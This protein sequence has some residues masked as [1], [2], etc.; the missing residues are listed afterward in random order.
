M[1]EHTLYMHPISQVMQ[2][3]APCRSE[4]LLMSEEDLADEAACRMKQF[5]H[6]EDAVCLDE[7]HASDL[8]RYPPW[9]QYC[10]P[11]WNNR[12][13]MFSNHQLSVAIFSW[14]F[15]SV[16]LSQ[17]SV[18]VTKKTS[19]RRSLGRRQSQSLLDDES[20]HAAMAFGGSMDG[21]N[22]KIVKWNNYE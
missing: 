10:L 16:S 6:T 15:L 21:L 11:N 1:F 18:A 3:G 4:K 2:L 22:V 17:E 7:N 5:V 12:F 14:L 9:N 20:S 8:L 13:S 19:V